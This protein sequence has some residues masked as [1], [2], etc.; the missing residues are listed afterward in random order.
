[1]LPD[2]DSFNLIH[3]R[4]D[5]PGIVRDIPLCPDCSLLA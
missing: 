4:S 1:M 3:G 5:F 2:I